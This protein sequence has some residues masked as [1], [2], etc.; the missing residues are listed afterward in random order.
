MAKKRLFLP[1][2]RGTKIKKLVTKETIGSAK[3]AFAMRSIGAF[4]K[5]AK[6][7]F[8]QHVCTKMGKITIKTSDKNARDAVFALVR[9]PTHNT[10][11]TPQEIHAVG[12][13]RTPERSR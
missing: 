7:S 11:V 1:F 12:E 4:A 10:S 2:L 3:S 9:K 8:L 13:G 6:K 5:L